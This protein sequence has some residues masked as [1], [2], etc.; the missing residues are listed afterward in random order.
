MTKK[1]ITKILIGFPVDLL[2]KIDRL[3][4]ER[5][6]DRTKLV[7]SILQGYDPSIDE[8]VETE[9]RRRIEKLEKEVKD[10]KKGR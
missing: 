1:Q 10:L 7:C 4:A 9:L 3:V 5:K 8:D 2:E 6:T